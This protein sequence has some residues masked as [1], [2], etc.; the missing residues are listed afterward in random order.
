MEPLPRGV[1]EWAYDRYIQDGIFP[2]NG[3]LT[4][5]AL[6]STFEIARLTGDLARLPAPGDAA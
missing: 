1:I 3:G 2:V 6:N 4:P 5:A